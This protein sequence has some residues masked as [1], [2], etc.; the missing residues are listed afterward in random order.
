MVVHSFHMISRPFS[1]MVIPLNRTHLTTAA[2]SFP[3]LKRTFAKKGKKELEK[4]EKEKA[5]SSSG[6]EIPKEIDL[7]VIETGYKEVIAKTTAAL[8]KM[9]FGSLTPEMIGNLS[10]SAY[11]EDSPMSELSQITLKN[12]TTAMINIYDQGLFNNIKKVTII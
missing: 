2:F 7:Q 3:S 10:V 9:K 8:A 1:A 4:E 5:R 6:V 12:D 11:G